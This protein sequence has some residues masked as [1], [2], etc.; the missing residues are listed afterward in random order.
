MKQGSARRGLPPSV[1][2]LG[3]GSLV[4]AWI[5]AA[6]WVDDDVFTRV[7]SNIAQLV[8]AVAAALAMAW[9]A[10]RASGRL[11]WT[12]GA[13]A[14]ACG[15]WAAGQAFWAQQEIMG[16]GIPFPSVADL[17]FLAF[18]VIGTFGLLLHPAE[19]GTRGRWQR[20]LDAVMTTAAV[21][22]VSWTTSLGA[23]V[24]E[25][26]EG[27]PLSAALLVA[28]PALDVV[29]IVLTVTTLA[30]SPKRGL[31]LILLGAGLVALSVSDSTF[32]YLM[33]TGAY[34]AEL[35]D[36]GWVLGFLLI[37][38]AGL[39]PVPEPGRSDGI[40]AARRTV[41]RTA[42]LPYVPVA[43]ALAT[44]L[45]VSLS[46][47]RSGSVEMVLITAVIGLLL[48]RQFLAL[49]ENEQMAAELAAREAM[50]R[51]QAFHDGLTGL[52]N[53]ALFRDR[54][55][56]AL[57]RHH[58]RNRGSVALVFLDL[59]DFKVVNDTL[60][61]AAGD[62]L[63]I[64]VAER[65]TA[66]VRAGDEVAR[67]GGDEFAVLLEDGDDAPAVTTRV[68]NALRAPVILRGCAVS[69]RASVGVCTLDADDGT[70]DADELLVRSDMAMYAAKRS[71][72]DQVVTYT[73]GLSLAEV[74][75]QLIRDQL[76]AAV[77]A[78]QVT[79]EY[80]P[81]LDVRTGRIVALEAL[82]R[83]NP[84]GI[85]VT[86]DVFI[87]VA[88]RSGLIDELTAQLLDEACGRVARWSADSGEPLS[89]HV[90]VAPSSLS[91]P[92]FVPAVAE[93]IDAHGLAPGQLILELTE[94]GLLEDRG[95]AERVVA[96]LR[97]IGVGV[98]LDDFGVG[99]SSLARLGAIP[100]DSVKIDRSFLERIDV[101]PRE[102]TLVRGVLRLARDM[103][104]PVV[105]EGVERPQQ[106]E[107]L[108]QMDCPMAQGFLLAPPMPAADVPAFLDHTVALA[109]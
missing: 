27:Q 15:S 90:N 56:H 67:L 71:G 77:A 10:R 106:L 68:L 32:A 80:Q 54:L 43:A 37:C 33:S 86:P 38:L 85:A 17:G 11:R 60:G 3:A 83:W 103:G 109:R 26:A 70:V 72:K 51:H 63:L 24:A 91:A 25:G 42:Y 58:P 104:L 74:E 66:A 76:R 39:V 61:H 65:L 94:T 107:M 101:D 49:R 78:G 73:T 20:S 36:G 95:S 22:L 98:S 89:V 62:E 45:V 46:G 59:D 97:G 13:L 100:L 108:R 69:V 14:I 84:G 41:V 7:V 102:A 105:A 48:S 9:R 18:P 52:A 92:G 23:V 55:E 19:G 34:D 5:V 82:A 30:R 96:A 1:A 47:G 44:S 53:R 16:R 87:P 79:L 75:E 21:G 31:E 88:E 6:A 2:L 4:L 64:R 93:I 28:Y 50:L 35:V 29:L 40:A 99:H 8:A 57:Q 81:I 12:W